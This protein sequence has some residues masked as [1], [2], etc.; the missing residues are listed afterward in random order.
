[1]KTKTRLSE[2]VCSNWTLPEL[3]VCHNTETVPE[4]SSVG[5]TPRTA[6]NADAQSDRLAWDCNEH[7]IVI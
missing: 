4:S 2:T 1:M 6:P 5:R 7:L 3:Q